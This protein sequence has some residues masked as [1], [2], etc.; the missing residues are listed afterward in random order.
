M[1]AAEEVAGEVVTHATLAE[2]LVAAQAAMPAVDKDS[3]NPH[4]KSKFTSLDHLIAKTRPVLNRHGLSI[5]QWPNYETIGSDDDGPTVLH[6]LTTIIRHT[7][8]EITSSTMPLI[9]GKNDMQ[10]LGSALTYAKRYAWAAALGI[11]TDEDDDGN[12]ASR[13]EVRQNATGTR[14]TRSQPQ[15]DPAPT[16]ASTEALSAFQA[17]VEAAGKDWPAVKHKLQEMPV[18]EERLA[19]YRQRLIDQLAADAAELEPL[20]FS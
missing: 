13:D 4:F 16:L 19:T 20:P 17:E 5:T 14:R 18:T 11:S 2:A 10:G 9:V 8:G 1:T 7:S 6:T 12:Q 15:S 3:V